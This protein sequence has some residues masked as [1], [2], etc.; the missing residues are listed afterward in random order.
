MRRISE[1]AYLPRIY[2][3]CLCILKRESVQ[4]IRKFKLELTLSD[5]NDMILI[6]GVRNEF[7]SQAIKNYN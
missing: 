1:V 4:N 2:I 7:R 5:V 3:I 6:G